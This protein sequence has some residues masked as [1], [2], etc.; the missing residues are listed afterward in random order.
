LCGGL[1]YLH[2]VAS[3]AKDKEAHPL[4]PESQ[5]VAVSSFAAFHQS[6]AASVNRSTRTAAQIP[7]SYIRAQQQD[8]GAT[9]IDSIAK[10]RTKDPE[11]CRPSSR[12]GA[13]HQD[14]RVSAEDST[15]RKKSQDSEDELFAKALSPRSPDLPRSPFSFSSKETLPFLKRSEK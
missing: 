7:P 10:K 5:D 9:S 6:P 4:S 11:A 13:Q 14:P 1:V 2:V 8:Y 12:S 3:L 15:G